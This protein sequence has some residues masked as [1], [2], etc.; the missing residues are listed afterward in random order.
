MSDVQRI[1]ESTQVFQIQHRAGDSSLTPIRALTPRTHSAVFFGDKLV[2]LSEGN[3]DDVLLLG[4]VRVVLPHKVAI[5]P[6]CLVGFAA[7]N[8]MRRRRHDARC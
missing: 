3:K 4:K 2:T 5:T 7:F 8:S 6:F 1:R